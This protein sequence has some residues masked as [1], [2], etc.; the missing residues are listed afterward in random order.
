MLLKRPM[1]GEGWVKF[2][3][4]TSGSMRHMPLLWSPYHRWRTGWPVKALIA[5][6]CRMMPEA[7]AVTEDNPNWF[8]S[9]VP[10]HNSVVVGTLSCVT[11]WAFALTA[12]ARMRVTHSKPRQIDSLRAL[13]CEDCVFV[14][15]LI[16]YPSFPSGSAELLETIAMESAARAASWAW[17]SRMPSHGRSK[18]ARLATGRNHVPVL[19]ATKER[20]TEA[21]KYKSEHGP[22]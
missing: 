9:C 1:P 13:G 17:H 4:S 5:V 21:R 6:P 19:F 2:G 11:F 3:S 15:F 12:N 22:L 10:A 14:M 18:D 7:G 20:K 16:R 8:Q